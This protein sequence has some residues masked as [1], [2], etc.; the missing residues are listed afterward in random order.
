MAGLLRRE[1]RIGAWS[2]VTTPSR[3]DT[4]P[5]INELLPEAI[6]HAGDDDEHPERDVDVDVAQVVRCRAADLKAA[7][8]FAHL[9]LERGPVVEVTAGDGAAG[10][11][12][13]DRALE[14]DGAASPPGH[15]G[16][17]VDDVVPDHDRLRLVLHHQ[18][19]VA[20]VP[21]PDQEAVHPLDVVRVQADR[22]LVVDVGDVGQRGAEVPDHL[23]PLRLPARQRAR[24]PLERKVAGARISANE[25]RSC[26]SAASS[27]A[28]E[29]SSTPRTQ[30]ARSEICMAHASAMLTP[31]IRDE[32]AALL[33]AI[34]L[35]LRGSSE[36]DRP[37]RERSDVRL[38]RVGVLGQD[39]SLQPQD[40]PFVSL[41]DA[42]DLHPDRLVV[43]Q[44][45]AVPSW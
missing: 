27:G 15:F 4:E 33:V 26:S 19:R 25:S 29:R 3:P 41:V 28:T 16:A 6:S 12:P 38:H 44:V 13:L 30:S 1:P 36:G 31:L 5:W 10:L 42:D 39:G 9:L 2:T 45:L 32:R 18:H 43:E 34:A 17:E 35:A 37:V 20:L 7:V 11:Q 8:G 14:A 40:Q 22:G 23:D 24:R 21:Q